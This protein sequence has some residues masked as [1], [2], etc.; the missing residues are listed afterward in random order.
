LDLFR[1]NRLYTWEFFKPIESEH[2]FSKIYPS[3]GKV[4]RLK[5]GWVR[6]SKV[7]DG[8]NATIVFTTQFPGTD[9]S[10]RMFLSWSLMEVNDFL[11]SSYSSEWIDSTH[12][13]RVPAELVEWT[14]NRDPDTGIVLP[15][16]VRSRVYAGDG[17]VE[18]DRTLDFTEGIINKGVSENDF[19]PEVFFELKEGDRLF[20]VPSQTELVFKN[21]KFISIQED[22]RSRVSQESNQPSPVSSQFYLLLINGVFLLLVAVLLLGRYFFFTKNAYDHM[23]IVLA[24]CLNSRPGPQVMPCMTN[25]TWDGL[26]SRHSGYLGA[27]AG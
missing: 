6:M 5:D 21:G 2:D 18:I 12:L 11:P 1:S 24:Y 17:T 9:G 19:D 16:K 15:L 25:R 3:I 14:Y 22:L 13:E 20:E 7:G 27:S 26:D 23:L 10:L 8:D 4:N